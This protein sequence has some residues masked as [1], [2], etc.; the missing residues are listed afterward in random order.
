M[1]SQVAIFS[2][3]Q[4]HFALVKFYAAA[5]IAYCYYSLRATVKSRTQFGKMC[6][7]EKS[8][9]DLSNLQLLFVRTS[10]CGQKDGIDDIFAYLVLCEL[11]WF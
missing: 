7:L 2:F 9:K 11:I 8:E 6:F 3:G 1:G 4:I 10:S 5:G